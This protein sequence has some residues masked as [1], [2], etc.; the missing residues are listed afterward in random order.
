MAFCDGLEALLRARVHSQTKRHLLDAVQGGMS[1]R[2]AGQRF[3]RRV[4]GISGLLFN[5]MY[6]PGSHDFQ[7]GGSRAGAPA[8]IFERTHHSP[9]PLEANHMMDSAPHSS[10]A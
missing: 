4:S 6:A 5:R 10:L 8:T 3:Q 7:L 2:G 1:A 9:C